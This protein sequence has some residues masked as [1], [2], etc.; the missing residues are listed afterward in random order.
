ML[1]VP[2]LRLVISDKASLPRLQYTSQM[3]FDT[4]KRRMLSP[5]PREDSAVKCL[6]FTSRRFGC[7]LSRTIHHLIISE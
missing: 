2:A 3:L 7:T 1:P 5:Q 4:R 6:V